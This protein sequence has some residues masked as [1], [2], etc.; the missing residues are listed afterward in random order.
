MRKLIPFILALLLVLTACG[1]KDTSHNH[2]K[3]NVVTTNSIIYDM[4]K[5]VGGNNVNIHSIVPVGQDP[6]EYEVKPKDI[7]KL[8]DA[9]VIFYNGLNLE[10]GDAWFENA[11]KQ[12]GKSLKDKNVI[13]VSKGVKPIYLNGENGNK[14]KL[15]PHAWLSLDNGIQYVKNIQQA[16][17]DIDK[18][19]AS[20]YDKH[21]NKYLNK[22]TKLNNHSKAKFND[23]PKKERTMI[24]SEGAFKYFSK[25]FNIHS[26]YIWEINTE[27]QGTP[28][29]MKQATKFVKDNKVK[30]LL[31]ETSVDK[32]AMQS[33]SEETNKDIYGEVFTDSI[34]KKGSKGDSYYNMMKYNIDIIHNSMK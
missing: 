32:K 31:V 23:I 17:K 29:Q 19:H 5:H 28:E 26:G 14:D 22:L 20:S 18:K 7:K 4:V 1:S 30:H 24:T 33:L 34:G 6:H 3:L 21:G 15:D 27:K 2:K 11:L 16:L 12:A 9:D 13:A 25:Q 8:T 10:S